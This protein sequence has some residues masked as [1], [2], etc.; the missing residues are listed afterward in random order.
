MA[1]EIVNRQKT[2]RVPRAVVRAAVMRV[3]IEELGRRVDVSLAFVTDAEI[4]GLNGKFLGHPGPTDV[5]TFALGEDEG[6]FGEIVISADRAA[7]EA[8]RRRLDPMR[9]LTLY[10]VHGMLHLAGY[11]DTTAADA[12]R[13]HRREAAVLRRFFA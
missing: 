11:D 4:A 12:R 13:M 1:V 10:A 5:I 8:R 6:A 3:M 7:D 9:E 2:L